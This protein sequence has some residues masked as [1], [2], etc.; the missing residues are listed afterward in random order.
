MPQ[1]LLTHVNA[2]LTNILEAYI[3]DDSPFLATQMFPVLPV[4]QDTDFY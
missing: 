3:Q 1:P 2:V 4:E